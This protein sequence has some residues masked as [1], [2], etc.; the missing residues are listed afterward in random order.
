M[1]TSQTDQGAERLAQ[2]S[3]IATTSRRG[4]ACC[5]GA[6]RREL[7]ERGI[8]TLSE[9]DLARLNRLLI[10][11]PYEEYFRPQPPKQIFITYFGFKIS[12]PIRAS[13]KLVKQIIEQIVLPAVIG[14]LVGFIGV[15]AAILVTAPIIP[16]MFDPG[17]LSLLLSKPVSRSL[18]FLAKF[19]GGC[20][21]I[22]INVTYLIVGLWGIVGLRLGIWSQGLLLC[23]PIFLFLFA[24]YYSVSAFSGVIWR[25]AVVCVVMTVLFWLAC[26]VVGIDQGRWSNRSRWKPSD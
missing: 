8:D 9:D 16:Q 2:E 13:E 11:T 22:L 4:A 21:F 1:P 10:E 15:L 12:P 26:T 25:N 20:A 7:L 3:R 5:W 23:I 19:V 14:V 18:M 24:I 17:S 6:K